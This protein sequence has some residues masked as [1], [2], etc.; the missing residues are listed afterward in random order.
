[1]VFVVYTEELVRFVLFGP[2]YEGSAWGLPMPSWESVCVWER[3]R[4]EKT[5]NPCSLDTCHVILILQF[6]TTIARG[7]DKNDPKKKKTL[8]LHEQDKIHQSA[9]NSTLWCDDQ[10]R[11]MSRLHPLGFCEK[12][13]QYQVNS[14][15]IPQPATKSPKN[16]NREPRTCGLFGI[17]KAEH[18]TRYT[19]GAIKWNPVTSWYGDLSHDFFIRFHKPQAMHQDD[20]L[21]FHSAPPHWNTSK[22]TIQQRLC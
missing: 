2:S 19:T 17:T 5:R 10:K 1:M 8:L 4:E 9:L 21:N 6:R 11:H 3:E 20:I 15:S 22:T 7:I 12:A 14:P 13:Q 18:L 16:P